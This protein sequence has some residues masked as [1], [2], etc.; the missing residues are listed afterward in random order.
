[1]LHKC[2][3]LSLRHMAPPFDKSVH[4]RRLIFYFYFQRGYSTDISYKGLV[5]IIKQ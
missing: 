3:C 2:F 5:Q 1:M 4:S